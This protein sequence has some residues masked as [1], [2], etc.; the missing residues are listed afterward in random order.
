M[1][2]KIIFILPFLIPFLSACKNIDNV[3]VDRLPAGLGDVNNLRYDNQAIYFDRVKDALKYRIE[4]EYNNEN[5]FTKDIK[6]NQYDVETLNLVGNNT[7]YVTAFNASKKSK[8]AKLDFT[9]TN[10]DSDTIYEG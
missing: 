5:V 8:K 3:N 9:I 1:K 7:V 10:I 4:I 6:V 2:K